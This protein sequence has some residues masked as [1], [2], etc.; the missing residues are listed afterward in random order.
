[1]RVAGGVSRSRR[2]NGRGAGQRREPHLLLG[3]SKPKPTRRTRLKRSE[4]ER[5]G[6]EEQRRPAA[7]HDVQNSA[8]AGS[9]LSSARLRKLRSLQVSEA[10]DLAE[11]HPSTAITVP[12]RRPL[13]CNSFEKVC[14][15][16]PRVTVASHCQ[17]YVISLHGSPVSAGTTSAARRERSVRGKACGVAVVRKVVRSAVT[18]GLKC[19]TVNY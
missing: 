16:T 6:G 18:V 4:A 13:Q 7:P 1:M 17:A 3:N 5:N 2:S 9:V 14:R 19:N 15:D 11:C 12:A 10:K 8:R